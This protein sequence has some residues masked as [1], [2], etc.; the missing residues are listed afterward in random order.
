[1][2]DFISAG[3]EGSSYE[4]DETLEG[5]EV[6]NAECRAAYDDNAIAET[7]KGFCCQAIGVD[8][9]TMGA[10]TSATE[11][12]GEVGEAFEIEGMEV[13]YG[14]EVFASARGLGASLAAI[15]SA[16]LVFSQ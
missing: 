7:Q 10:I 2:T 16:T 3:D 15:A 11:L 13:T 5:Q 8:G 9:T 12:S 14:A 4:E 1:M 6:A